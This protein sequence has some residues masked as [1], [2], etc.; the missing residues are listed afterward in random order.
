MYAAGNCDLDVLFCD[1]YSTQLHVDPL[2]F[3]LRVLFAYT[4]LAECILL[5]AWSR[6]SFLHSL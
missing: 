3:L 4:L 1:T 6:G 5:E 2:F